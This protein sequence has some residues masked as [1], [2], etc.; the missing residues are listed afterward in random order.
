LPTELQFWLNY[1]PNRL[2]AVASPESSLG[3]LQRPLSFPSW[4]R[5]MGPKRREG[6]IE[7]EGKN[8]KFG[9]SGAYP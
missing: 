7:R 9:H 8:V 5:E 1:A 6:E 3:S 2:S 4:F